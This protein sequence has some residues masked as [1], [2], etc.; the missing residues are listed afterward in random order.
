CR[1]IRRTS[2]AQQIV[3]PTRLA[4]RRAVGWA[5]HRGIRLPAPVLALPAPLPAARAMS[6]H[7]GSV[8]ATPGAEATSPRGAL[9]KPYEMLVRP[10]QLRVVRLPSA[11]RGLARTRRA[12]PVRVG[13]AVP[14]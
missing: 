8:P 1:G 2:R 11:C 9:A 6:H 5:A 10:V 4:A 12:V 14:T 13:R 3:R 7:E